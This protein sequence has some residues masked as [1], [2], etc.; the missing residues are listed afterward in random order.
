MRQ[1]I[2]SKEGFLADNGVCSLENNWGALSTAIQE[3]NQGVS[4]KPVQLQSANYSQYNVSSV[5]S[6]PAASPAIMKFVCRDRASDQFSPISFV[7]ANEDTCAYPN[8]NVRS[9]ARNDLSC[10]SVVSLKVHVVVENNKE[11]KEC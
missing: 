2:E 8:P 1:S 5:D 11:F 3:S 9:S 6:R 7:L 4:A 10:G